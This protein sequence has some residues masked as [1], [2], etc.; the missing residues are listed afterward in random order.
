L[1]T[2]FD[3]TGFKGIAFKLKEAIYRFLQTNRNKPFKIASN[4]FLSAHD[5]NYLKSLLNPV[6]C[7][8]NHS[9]NGIGQNSKHSASRFFSDFRALNLYKNLQIYKYLRG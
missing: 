5:S 3:L 2:I 4:L 7:L 1:T 8:Q 9:S 6:V